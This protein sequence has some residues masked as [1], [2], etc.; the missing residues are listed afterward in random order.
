LKGYT[1]FK[2]CLFTDMIYN[3]TQYL[4]VSELCKVERS[5]KSGT[6]LLNSEHFYAHIKAEFIAVSSDNTGES[7]FFLEIQ[8]V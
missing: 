2:S 1:C 3:K 5:E 8:C 7:F 6:F 4:Y